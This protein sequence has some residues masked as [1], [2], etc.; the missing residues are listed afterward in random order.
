M[1]ARRVASASGQKPN[2]P[3]ASTEGGIHEPWVPASRAPGLAGLEHFGWPV[4]EH[5][6]WPV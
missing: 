2:D 3:K 5:Y 4:W 1:S 6:R